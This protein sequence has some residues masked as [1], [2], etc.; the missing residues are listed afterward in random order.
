MP[1]LLVVV[2]ASCLLVVVSDDICFPRHSELMP[3]CLACLPKYGDNVG[4]GQHVGH[5][6]N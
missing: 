6:S 4:V 1:C 5:I 2:T 3:S